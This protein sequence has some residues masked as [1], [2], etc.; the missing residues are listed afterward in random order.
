MYIRTKNIN[1]HLYH[2]LV[3]SVREGKRVI[4]KHLKY[5]GK[6]IFDNKTIKYL[7]KETIKD[8][9]NTLVENS[10]EDKGIIYEGFL[11]Y[12]NDYIVDKYEHVKNTKER[13]I[14]KA[15]AM[16]YHSLK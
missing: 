3:K 4:Q 14:K 7:P 2:Y 6:S 13:L 15:S 5:L 8:L 1:G 9:Q 12:I 11:D 10:K 16:N